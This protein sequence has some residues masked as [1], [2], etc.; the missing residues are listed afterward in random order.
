MHAP[1]HLQGQRWHCIAPATPASGT[2]LVAQVY[3]LHGAIRP[4]N[5]A[6]STKM[7]R[8]LADL[9]SLRQK[10]GGV[11]ILTDS[12]LAGRQARRLRL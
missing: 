7:S 10:R 11:V 12:D 9:A 3:V 8:V 4:N 2:A 5:A 1:Q 6:K